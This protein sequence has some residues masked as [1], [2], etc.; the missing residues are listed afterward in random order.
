MVRNVCAWGKNFSSNWKRQIGYVLETGVVD[1]DNVNLDESSVAVESSE[2][3][4]SKRRFGMAMLKPGL[5]SVSANCVGEPLL[6]CCSRTLANLLANSESPTCRKDHILQ[7]KRLNSQ[8]P[9]C[10]RCFRPRYEAL[11]DLV[12][13]TQSQIAGSDNTLDSFKHICSSLCLELLLQCHLVT[14]QFAVLQQQL[15]HRV[16]QIHLPRW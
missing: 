15:I 8:N 9:T 11:F 12:A 7:I 3:A 16:Y 5:P 1:R 10:H 13:C 2:A 14:P 6:R 4:A